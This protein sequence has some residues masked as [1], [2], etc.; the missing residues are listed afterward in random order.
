MKKLIIL[1]LF[2]V[3]LSATAQKQIYEA[4]NL[5]EVIARHKRVAILPFYVAITHRK[6]NEALSA[7]MNRQQEQTMAKSIQTSMYTFLLRKRKEYTVEFQDV[8]KTN[9]LLKRAGVLDKLEDLTKDEIAKILEVDAIISGKFENEQTRSDRQARNNALWLGTG[10]K[11][12]SGT[13]TMVLNEGATGEMVWRF[14][15]TMDDNYRKSTDDLVESMM[16]KL[17]R[18]FPYTK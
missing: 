12:G 6:Q 16:R 1:A 8:D 9:I 7:E 14:Y 2:T 18:N 15:K 3:S 10:G 17:S 11:T 5:K 13:L 4:D